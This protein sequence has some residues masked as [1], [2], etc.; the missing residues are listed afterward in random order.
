MI[1]WTW[2][3]LWIPILAL[4]I[5]NSLLIPILTFVFLM[6]I[7][8]FRMARGEDFNVMAKRLNSN[9]DV[10]HLMAW[11]QPITK[12][13]LANLVENNDEIEDVIMH[14]DKSSA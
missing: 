9:G 12:P 11:E 3:G 6:L 14:D 10:Q 4:T 8:R 2:N 1:K 7:F 13:F 5:G